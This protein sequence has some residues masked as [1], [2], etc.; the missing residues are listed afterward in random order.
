MMPVPEYMRSRRLAKVMGLD[1]REVDLPGQQSHVLGGRGPRNR[2]RCGRRRDQPRLK[3]DQQRKPPR[4]RGQRPPPRRDGTRGADIPGPL[5][6]FSW[7]SAHN[8][9]RFP[10]LAGEI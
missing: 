6:R 5:H 7:R 2:H 10:K 9:L 8:L 1:H 3:G 4:D